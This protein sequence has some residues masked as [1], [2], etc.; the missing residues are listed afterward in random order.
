MVVWK[1]SKTLE[2]CK[3]FAKSLFEKIDM[4]NLKAVPVGMLP[5]IKGIIDEPA[6][7]DAPMIKQFKNAQ[8]VI[9]DHIARGT[10]IGYEHGPSIEAG[11]S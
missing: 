8:D 10:A 6:Y 3:E 4:T 7:K 2:I 9:V 11:I 1:N 5:S